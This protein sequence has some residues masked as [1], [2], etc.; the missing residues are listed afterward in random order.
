LPD[1]SLF[2]APIVMREMNNEQIAQVYDVW[3]LI[4]C[5]TAKSIV[6]DRIVDFPFN[7]LFWDLVLG[8]KTSLFDLNKIQPEVAKNFVD[9]QRMANRRK[10]I[11]QKVSDP[12]VLERQLS[13]IKTSFGAPIEEI[14]LNFTLPGDPSIELKPD[15]AK[16]AVNLENLQEYIDMTLHYTFHETLKLQLNAFKKG[17]NSIFSLESLKCFSY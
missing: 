6:D 12:E 17:F 11:V 5:V 2:P 9:F 16:I 4:G 8:K 13:N 14:G 7:A 3:R 1:N 10:Q 15:G